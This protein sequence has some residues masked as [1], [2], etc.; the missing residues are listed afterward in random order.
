VSDGASSD[1]YDALVD[2]ANVGYAALADTIGGQPSCHYLSPGPPPWDTYPC[3]V[4]WAGA[5]AVGDTFPLQPSLQTMHRIELGRQVNLIP[6]TAIAL[7]CGPIPE[8]TG[9]L[10]NWP[11]RQDK[12]TQEILSDVWALWNHLRQ[13]KQDLTLFPPKEREFSLEV[14]VAYGPSGGA[15]GATVT[16]R[17]QLG[18][19][20]PT[21]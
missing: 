7:R 18:G 14:G 1:L 9:T 2:F 8:N 5:P 19:Y 6:L 16:A 20:D 11:E 10:A 17:V 13:A 15:V 21:S 3:F 4:A 12:A